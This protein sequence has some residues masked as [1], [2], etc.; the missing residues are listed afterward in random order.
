MTPA[1]EDDMDRSRRSATLAVAAIA[2]VALGGCHFALREPEPL[3]VA[4]LYVMG[5]APGMDGTEIDP[6]FN[7]RVQTIEIV[8]GTAG[9]HDRVI[10]MTVP[11]GTVILAEFEDEAAG[12]FG[13]RVR[14]VRLT[15]PDVATARGL[16]V[17]DGASRVRRLYGEPASVGDGVWRYTVPGAHGERYAMDVAMDAGR[18]TAITFGLATSE[19][20]ALERPVQGSPWNR[21]G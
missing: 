12:T 1:G 18:V 11:G 17:G 10:V 3:R 21:P 15:G 8:A 6:A 7:R 4:D 2:A 14:T 16:E 20:R 13:A 5:I 9:D 19:P